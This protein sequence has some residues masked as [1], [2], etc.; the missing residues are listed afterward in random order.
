MNCDFYLMLTNCAKSTYRFFCQEVKLSVHWR[1]QKWIF[2][3]VFYVLENMS[4]GLIPKEAKNR[5]DINCQLT[6]HC[7]SDPLDAHQNHKNK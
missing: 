1:V 4:C 5:C 2:E 7:R 6:F 3:E